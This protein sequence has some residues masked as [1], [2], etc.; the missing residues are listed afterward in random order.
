MKLIQVSILT[1][2]FKVASGLATFY[3]ARSVSRCFVSHPIVVHPSRSNF[4]GKQKLSALHFSSSSF[5]ALSSYSTESDRCHVQTPNEKQMAKDAI[6]IINS[7]IDAVNPFNAVTKHLSYCSRDHTLSLFNS[8]NHKDNN[9]TIYPLQDFSQIYIASI[10]KAASAMALATAQIVSES[11]LPI[12]GIVIT[13]DDHATEDQIERLS[14]LGIEVY[15][16]SHPVP[17]QRSIAYSRTL[18]SQLENIT[19]KGTTLVISCISGGGSSL[20]CTPKENL[21]LYHMARMN[22]CL[23]ACGMPIQE[24][25]V[26][27]KRVEVGKGGGLVSIAY[28]ATCINMVLSDVIGDPLDLIASGPTV[29]DQSSWEDARRLVQQYDLGK[30]GKYELPEEILSIISKGKD[31]KEE[32][33]MHNEEDIFSKSQT[34]LVGNNLLAVTAAAL[35]AQNCGYNPI[36][37]GSSIQGEAVPIANMYVSLAE[38]L[39]AQKSNPNLIPFA[40]AKLPAAILVGGET[41]VTLSDDHGLGGRNQE[42]GL[43]AALKLKSLALRDVV[44]ASVGTDGTDGPTDAAGA[45]VDGGTVS[46]IE[47]ENNM[48]ISGEEALRRHD[49][50]HFFASTH[51]DRALIKTGP[52]GTNVADVCVILVR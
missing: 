51:T 16:A 13:K 9:L 15:F 50:Y 43:A 46:R 28:P 31:I 48:S 8:G 34:V 5:T 32:K 1:H 36:V 4:L 38:H 19:S 33:S 35:E 6:S 41:V 39:Q 29:R 27:R 42:I 30:G 49:A 14:T 17:D 23:L 40:L 21:D 44:I 7:A 26:L 45:V 37:L 47:V 10:G 11:N 24:V 25:N 20:F 52:T 3:S 12:R 22:E 18:L 2:S